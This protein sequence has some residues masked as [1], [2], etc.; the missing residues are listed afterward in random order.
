MPK[1]TL[2]AI[3]PSRAGHMMNMAALKN[4][5]ASVPFF[6]KLILSSYY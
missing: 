5:M 3:G 1:Q 4:K 2:L 6:A